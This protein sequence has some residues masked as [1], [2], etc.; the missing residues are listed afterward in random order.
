MSRIQTPS[1]NWESGLTWESGIHWEGAALYEQLIAEATDSFMLVEIGFSTP[2][3][4]T[5]YGA[6]ITWNGY[7]WIAQDVK[8]T[9]LTQ[10]KGGVSVGSIEIQN[11]DDTLSALLLI[12]GARDKTVKVYEG[13]YDSAG[14]LVGMVNIFT[15]GRTNGAKLTEKAAVLEIA[16]ER[17]SQLGR[18][19]RR[20]MNTA[21]GF[22]HLLPDGTKITWKGE[23]FEVSS[24]GGAA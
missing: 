10:H 14:N 11:M 22:N 5:D 8:V 4:I 7:T 20:W 23:D 2:L 13:Y 1:V 17:A 15:N 18:A 6:N 24:R 12:E 19:P 3:R 16:E 21:T 9:G